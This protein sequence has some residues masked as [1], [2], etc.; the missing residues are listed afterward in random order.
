MTCDVSNGC[1]WCQ[2]ANYDF[3]DTDTI[4]QRAIFICNMHKAR[5]KANKYF[6]GKLD[7]I[8]AKDGRK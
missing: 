7:E 3:A 2:G 6:W 5:V 1:A 4:Y 8:T